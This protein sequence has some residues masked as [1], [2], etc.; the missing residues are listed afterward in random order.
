ML[1][2]EDNLEPKGTRT[3]DEEI[4]S[5]NFVKAYEETYGHKKI[6]KATLNKLLGNMDLWL[7][8]QQRKELNRCRADRIFVHGWCLKQMSPSSG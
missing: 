2:E 1:S 6:N 7:S 4:I 8:K 5:D 3:D